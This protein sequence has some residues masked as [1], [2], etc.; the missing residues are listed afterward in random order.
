LDERFASYVKRETKFV[1][2]QLGLRACIEIDRDQT[3]LVEAS[4]ALRQVQPIVKE[5][6]AAA[7]T[8]LL[9]WPTK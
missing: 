5:R 6:T 1:E 4:E 7:P 3:L 8:R 2:Q 9:S